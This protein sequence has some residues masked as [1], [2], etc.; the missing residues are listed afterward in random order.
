MAGE[1]I[2]T[3]A[4][5][6]LGDSVCHGTVHVQDGVIR[7]IETGVS[8][9]PA[10][11]DLEG[12]F[13]I[14]GLIDIHTDNLERHLQPRPGVAWPN[15]A[16]LVTHDR[17]MATAGV[18]TVFDSL[19]VGIGDDDGNGRSKALIQSLLAMEQAQ[20]DGLLKAEHFLHL[21]C[22]VT[23]PT[24]VSSFVALVD[25]PLVRLV[26]V[27]D[28][29]LGQ[30]QWQ[31][32]DNW[33]KFTGH[34]PSEAELERMLAA[35]REM[36]A[37]YAAANRLQ[38]VR[39]SQERQLTLASHDDATVEHVQDAVDLGISISEFPTT[40]EAAAK[41]RACGLWIVMGAPNVVLGGSHSGNV[42][43]R[44]LAAD[45]LVDGLASDYV[46]VS[47]IHA[48]FL[49]HELLGVALPDAVATASAHPAAMVGLSDRGIIA[50]DR[51][52]DLVW[53]K[54]Y[55][56]VPVVRSVWRR[57]MLVA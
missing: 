37:R 48:C 30:R 56:H 23:S 53:V 18:T 10:A 38:I 51:L 32:V 5:V 28:H 57:G 31:N 29:T 41:A 12:D 2:L 7:S 36:Q 11:V 25:D 47:L 3:N 34:E 19:C 46:P 1:L 39:A 17:Q 52:A 21:R 54:A 49:F 8:R 15:I 44:A 26:S 9:L 6:V 4:Q 55:Q 13:L 50:P 16:A 14:P 27:M 43:A 45:G 22:E 20:A 33:M 42:S 24:V 40:R 35:A